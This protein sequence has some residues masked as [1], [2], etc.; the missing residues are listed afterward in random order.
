MNPLYSSLPE[1]LIAFDL[2][3]DGMGAQLTDACRAWGAC[4]RVARLA[5]N[6]VVLVVQ[7]GGARS[8]GL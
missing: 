7:A 3:V 5:P 2:R 4:A 1:V 6:R 8:L